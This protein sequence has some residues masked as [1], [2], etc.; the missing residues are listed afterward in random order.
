MPQAVLTLRCRGQTAGGWEWLLRRR[1]RT[2]SAREKGRREEAPR[3]AVRV[4][5]TGES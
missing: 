3:V 2:R 1:Q 5:L 4:C